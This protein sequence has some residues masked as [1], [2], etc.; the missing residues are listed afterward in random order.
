MRPSIQP[1]GDGFHS[2][3]R[4]YTDLG[5]EMLQHSFDGRETQICSLLCE[6]NVQ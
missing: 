5:E 3:E 6:G 2:Q 4:V 1:D